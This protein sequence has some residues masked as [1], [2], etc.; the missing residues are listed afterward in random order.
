MKKLLLAI[1]AFVLL[2]LPSVAQTAKVQALFL[3]Q[4]AKYT[5]WP[6]E[7]AGKP[8]VISVVGDRDMAEELRKAT[9]GKSVGGRSIDIILAP[10]ALKLPTSDIIYLGQG[11]NGWL[12]KVLSDQAGRSVMV[13]CANQGQCQQ[14]ACVSFVSG[15]NKVTFEVCERNLAKHGLHMAPKLVAMGRQIP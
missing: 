5:G 3:Y 6:K 14:G 12:A 2:A 11:M 7:D 9:E 4:F 1:F 15:G 10:T 8:F 13:V